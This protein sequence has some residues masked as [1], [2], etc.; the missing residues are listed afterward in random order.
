LRV[1][2]NSVRN[3]AKH[4]PR[5]RGEVPLKLLFPLDCCIFPALRR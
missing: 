2:T 1:H 4:V 5:I 3:A